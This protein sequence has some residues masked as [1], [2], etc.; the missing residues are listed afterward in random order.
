MAC[1]AH[2]WG[3]DRCAAVPAI[4]ALPGIA[5]WQPTQGGKPHCG[6]VMALA[7]AEPSNKNIR[8]CIFP[9]DESFGDA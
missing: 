7:Y 8:Y 3:V 1:V 6:P 2:D 4:A 9:L 5:Q